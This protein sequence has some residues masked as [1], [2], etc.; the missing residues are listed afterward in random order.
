M[1]KRDYYEVLGVSK[2]ASDDELKKK[3]RQLARKYHPDV[4]KEP[5]AKEKFSEI[6][7][8]YSVLSDKEKRAQYDQFGFNAPGSSGGFEGFNPFDLFRRHFGGNPFG[9][10]ND[11]DDVFSPFGFSSKRQKKPDFDSPEDGSDM[12]MTMKLTFKESLFGCIKD[13]D[14]TLADECPE[15]KGRGIEKGSTPE[16]CTHCNGTGHIVN[17]QRNGFMMSQTISA[18]PYCHGQGVMSTPCKRCH[19]SK[20]IPA[21][22]HISVKVPPGMQTGQRLKVKGKGECG[23]KGGSN[24][25]IYIVVQVD[26]SMLFSRNGNDLST[27]VPIDAIT[28]TFGGK[29]EVQTP[30][31]KQSID[32]SP[33]TANGTKYIINKHG[34][35]DANGNSGNLI[36]KVEIQPFNALDNSQKTLLNTLKKQMKKNNV[37]GYGK[38]ESM[39][40]D[41][42]KSN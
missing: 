20:R 4:C 9:F 10:G 3:Y 17:I 38:Y 32:I 8:A 6:S 34:V 12:Q 15:C 37:Y 19:G 36:V 39:S 18:C 40:N 1:A 21:K 27:V 25:D 35:R 22:K 5:D 41:F 28:A 42:V 23:V 16:K 26:S 33:G 29:V 30:Y 13:I 24:G 7:E 2:D 11:E 31:G 14:L